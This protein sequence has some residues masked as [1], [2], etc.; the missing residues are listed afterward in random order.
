MAF[1][2]RFAACLLDR[3]REK[4][5][6]VAGA[7]LTRDAV[8]V[9]LLRI[10]GLDL[11]VV[12]TNDVNFLYFLRLRLGSGAMGGSWLAGAEIRRQRV[13]LGF[14]FLNRSANSSAYLMPMISI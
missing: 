10:D 11:N 1:A 4:M 3:R 13:V 14:Y 12:V 6:Y 2:N 7:L 9:G 5:V 8:T